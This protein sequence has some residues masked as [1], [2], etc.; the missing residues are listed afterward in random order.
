MTTTIH[1]LLFEAEQPKIS[2]ILLGQ[3]KLIQVFASEEDAYRYSRTLRGLPASKI[4]S[5]EINDLINY[6]RTTS[7]GVR[8]IPAG[9]QVK[10]TIRENIELVEWFTS[11]NYTSVKFVHVLLFNSG[12]ENEGVHSL[13]IADYDMVL[14]FEAEDDATR[15][16]LLLEAQDF[17]TPTVESIYIEEMIDSCVSAGY[18]WQLVKTE[19]LVVPPTDNLEQL[20]WQ[21]EEPL[22]EQEDIEA[23]RRK[24]EGLL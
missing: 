21:K 18:A 22:E 20:D 5:V 12:K 2:S 16:A 19:G 6:A 3:Y 23:L 4:I 10:S 11:P 7:Y 24:L 15:Y 17:P 14:L 8:I 9:T 1:I 13:K